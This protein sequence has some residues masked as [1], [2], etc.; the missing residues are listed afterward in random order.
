MHVNNALSVMVIRI[1]MLIQLM[2]I[3]QVSITDLAIIN[4]RQCILIATGVVPCHY[5]ILMWEK[6]SWMLLIINSSQLA[7]S[8]KIGAVSYL[9]R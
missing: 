5:Q 6:Q 3:W 1:I 4:H 9:Q 8:A 7:W 2:L